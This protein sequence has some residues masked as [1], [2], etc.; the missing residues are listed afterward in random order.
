MVRPCRLRTILTLLAPA[1]GGPALLFAWPGIVLAHQLNEKYQ[2][3]LPLAI[4]VGG[5]AFAVGM[6]FVFVI[7][8]NAP[9]PKTEVSGTPRTLPRWLR[10]TLQAIGLV[11]W[12]WIV[13][14]TFFGGAGDGDVAS[15][16]L[17]VYGWVALALISALLGPVWSWIDPFSTIHAIL[18]GVTRR[19]G[20]SGGESAHYPHR[21]GKWPA[22]IGLAVIV[23]LELVGRVEGG[24]SLGLFLV[25]Y[26]VFTVGAM[27]YFG[28]QAWRANGE[29]FSVWFGVLGRLAPFALDGE[30]EGGRLIRRPYASGL[31]SA[32]W[33]PAD[34]ALVAV[35]TGSIIFD[36]LSQ[37]QAYFDLFEKNGL[38]G[39]DTVRDSIT[40][41][42]F[43]GGLLLIVLLM[44]RRLGVATL[45][46]GLLPV[47]LGY[48]VAHY[49][50]YL[51]VD[52]QRIIAA[53][54]DPLLRGQNLLP[55]DLGFWE[56]TLPLPTSVLWSLQL[57]AVVGG[58]IVGA[59]AG[60]AEMAR[61]K[62]GTTVLAQLPLAVL[63][64]V[65]TTITLWSLGQAVLV[66]PSS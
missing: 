16:F 30:P 39:S 42:V 40:S 4:Y 21:L 53:L 17:W 26:T 50:S 11:G 57:A 60:H 54:N 58:H 34:L 51:L 13:A 61:E 6:S 23:W 41:L 52:G 65:L 46:A 62:T 10:V 64:V 31:L 27:A 29:T 5:A 8:R 45:G 48:L 55:F 44:S 2:A 25:G 12:L 9:A 38:F 36:G 22:V 37:T 1:A 18:S 47:A 15:L 28:K 33:T 7:L 43:I 66:T 20:I 49:L 32:I 19:A 24:R 14:Q 59:W 56:P 35:G 63:M 3:P